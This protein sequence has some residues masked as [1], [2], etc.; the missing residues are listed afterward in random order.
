MTSIDKKEEIGFNSTQLRRLWRPFSELDRVRP[1]AA[2]LGERGKGRGGELQR[3][4]EATEGRKNR[5]AI[6]LA[7]RAHQFFGL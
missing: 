3:A 4:A 6:L 1:G 2:Y 7:F 5:G